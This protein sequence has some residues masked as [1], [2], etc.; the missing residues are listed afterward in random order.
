MSIE[1]PADLEGLI[2]AGRAARACLEEMRRGVRPGVTTAEL[3]AIAAATL[4]RWGARSAPVQV[5]GFPGQTCIS[6]NEEVVH[7]IPSARALVE[8]D[9]VKL[10]VTVEKDGYMAD[11]CETVEVGQVKPLMRRLAECSRRAL[12]AGLAVARAGNRLN[13]IGRAV[14]RTV[15]RDGFKVVRELSGHGIGRTIHEA[16]EVLNYY[17]PRV[18]DV[19]REGLVITVEPIIAAG[20]GTSYERSDGWTVATVDGG[21]SAHSEHTIVITKERPVV[22]TAA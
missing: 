4:R 2:Q 13:Q 20:L 19:L 16:P 15:E 18:K 9:L 5:Y 7:G 14:Q 11:T 8:G 17:D 21:P 10:D 6:V 3:D 22:L 1:D 12:A